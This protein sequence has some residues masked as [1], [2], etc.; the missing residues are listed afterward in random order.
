MNTNDLAQLLDRLRHEPHETEW[1]EFKSNRY[2]PEVLGEY[3]SALAN[4]ACLHGKARG[5]L[6]FGIE[7]Q[8]HA[9]IGTTFNPRGEKA[10]GNQDL[11][12]WIGT[13]LQP[14]VGFE[15][16][17]FEYHGK[18]VVLFEIGAAYDR[19]VRFRG[20]A[21]I[22]VGSCKT[23]LA[24]Y[25][26]KERAIWN[27]RTDWSA[28][29]CERA[30]LADLDPEAIAAARKQFSI[31]NPARARDVEGWDDRTFLNKAK[32]TIQGAITNAAI[33]LLGREESAPLISPAV[34]RI[35]WI[36]KDAGNT[37]LD[38]QHFGPPFVT[39][40]DRVLG[41]IRNL[42]IRQLP[43]GTL[44]PAEITQYDT[45][46]IREALHNCIA[47]QDYGLHG[48]INVVETPDGL[49]LSN[50]GSFL[51]GSVET[52]IRQ[53]APLEVYRNHFLAEAMVNLNMIDTQGGGIK[54]MF[55]KQASRFFPLPDYDLTDPGR[56]VVT[57][58]GRVLD[59]R[60]TRLLMNRTN[61]DLSTVILLDKVQKNAPITRDEHRTLKEMKLVEG[62]Y[63]NLFVSAPIAAMTG[64]KAQHIRNR[65][66]DRQYYLD[67]ILALI[68]EHGPVSR[69]DIDR[70]LLDKL[71]DVLS[72]QQK[73][74][75]IHNLLRE[76]AG[77]AGKIRNSGS[78]RT[79][80][81][82]CDIQSA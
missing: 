21:F 37:E 46:V 39:N 56:V 59:E 53:D 12:I 1:L 25:P 64:Q 7:D 72:G 19:P 79:P 4:A 13:G 71:P 57:L 75:K 17:P 76:L 35:S 67:M 54:R 26:E 15:V 29:V 66:F 8:S 11:L 14:N 47:H 18:P 2:D 24:K 20:Y 41:R 68:R 69:S 44:F 28:Q 9:V 32:L 42:T 33:L 50:A 3:I 52:V 48:R 40:V 58:R 70:L 80:Q 60:Y 73:K 51:P 62:R 16:H 82:T 22:R 63:P 55:Q 45:W 23:D 5:Y 31:K 77:P 43:G 10:K 38:Y 78:R 74:T 34:A 65:G 81:W 27:R 30:T 36:L 49:L 61:L 6:V